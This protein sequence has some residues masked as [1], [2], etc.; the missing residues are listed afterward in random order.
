MGK[1]EIASRL[2]K[3][4]EEAKKTQEEAAAVLKTSYQRISNWER[5]VSRIDMDS[6]VALCAFYDASLEWIIKGTKENYKKRD[7]CDNWAHP[8]L[9]A[10]ISADDSTR[11]AACNVLRIDYVEP[12]EDY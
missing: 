5:G 7:D 9:S 10:Y 11:R 12:G 8:I 4:R 1:L 6:L 2:Q 3:A